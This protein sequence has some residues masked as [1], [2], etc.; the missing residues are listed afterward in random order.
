M[1]A[2]TVAVSS[3]ASVFWDL[4]VQPADTTTS[5]ARTPTHTAIAVR[6]DLGVVE[7]ILSR[8]W[9]DSVALTVP[10]KKRQWVLV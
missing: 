6:L 7:W 8:S 9:R 4:G 10:A 1:A 5:N 3:A 2:P